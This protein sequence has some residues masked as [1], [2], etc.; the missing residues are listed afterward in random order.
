MTEPP[1]PPFRPR[2]P[3]AMIILTIGVTLDDGTPA[4]HETWAIGKTVNDA[5]QNWVK[6]HPK[7][8]SR[9]RSRRVVSTWE[10]R[11]DLLRDRR[12]LQR[13]RFRT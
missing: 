6:K 12:A 10:T 8:A 1:E 11:G 9:V 3:I 5:L 7:M 4:T 2:Y 13:D